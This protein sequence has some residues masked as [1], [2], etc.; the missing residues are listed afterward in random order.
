MVEYK[1][2]LDKNTLGKET[3]TGAKRRRQLSPSH[4]TASTSSSNRFI[5]LD[6]DMGIPQNDDSSSDNK[7]SKEE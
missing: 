6:T 7:D 2:E 1:T 5:P 4:D 3:R